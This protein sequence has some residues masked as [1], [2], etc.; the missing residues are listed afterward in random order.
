MQVTQN[1]V[2]EDILNREFEDKVDLIRKVW[3]KYLKNKPYVM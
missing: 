1:T 2:L 3:R